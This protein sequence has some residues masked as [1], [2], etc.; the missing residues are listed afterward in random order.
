MDHEAGYFKEME[1]HMN[2]RKFCDVT[3]LTLAG[4]IGVLLCLEFVTYTG[5]WSS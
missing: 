3:V 4:N 1:Q 5:A 2:V